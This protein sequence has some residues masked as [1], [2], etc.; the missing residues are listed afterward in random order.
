[1]QN[2]VAGVITL[3]REVWSWIHPC[4]VCGLHRDGGGEI[5][6]ATRPTHAY[7]WLIGRGVG[8]ISKPCGRLHT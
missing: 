7:S 4:H 3:W 2:H 6:C 5:S 1:M 8:L